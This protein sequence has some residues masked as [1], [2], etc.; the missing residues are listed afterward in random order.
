MV[1]RKDYLSGDPRGLKE[2][3]TLLK[4]IMIL[5]F[6]IIF[7]YGLFQDVNFIIRAIGSFSVLY[8]GLFLKF[9]DPKKA[10]D[11]LASRTS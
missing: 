7:S 4:A 3:D 5:P 11:Y 6:V 8:V 10:P 1:I 2:E 9:R